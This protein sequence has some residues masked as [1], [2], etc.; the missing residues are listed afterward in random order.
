MTERENKLKKKTKLPSDLNM[1][2]DMIDE[3]RNERRIHELAQQDAGL[4]MKEIDDEINTI[5]DHAQVIL[6]L[7]KAPKPPK[8]VP[9]SN[10]VNKNTP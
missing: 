9:A 10:K 6:G 2:R 4:N 7:K 8:E 3:R 1:V 5:A